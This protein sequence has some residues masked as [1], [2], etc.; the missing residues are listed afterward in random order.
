MKFRPF[1][2]REDITQGEYIK[3]RVFVQEMKPEVWDRIELL[4]EEL[5]YNVLV[6]AAVKA[7][8]LED[9]VEENEYEEETVWQW[10]DE[11]VNGL[12][13]GDAP[14]VEWGRQVLDRWVKYKSIDPN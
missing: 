5:F 8:W 11:Y 1:N 13:A 12:P 3:F 6:L 2:L 4:P 10:T 9:V 7:G 14:V